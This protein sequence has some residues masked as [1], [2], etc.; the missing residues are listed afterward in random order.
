MMMHYSCVV[1]LVAIAAASFAPHRA[2]SQAPGP[3]LLQLESKIPL[4]DVTG[5][6]DHLA[7]DLSRRRL[8]VAELGNDTVGVVD[9]NGQRVQHVITGLKEPQG[10]GYV[11]SSDTLFVANAGDGSVLLFRS[12]DYDA[13]GRIE[14]GHDAD[15][16]RVDTASNRVFVGYGSG[17]LAVIDPATNGKVAEIQ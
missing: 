10:V 6:I 17:A 13:A 1:F 4:G 7:I 16:I 11:P 14:L 8:F 5:R 3:A 9:L 2:L 15:N 12:A